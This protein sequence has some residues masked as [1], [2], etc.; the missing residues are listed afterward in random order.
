MTAHYSLRTLI[1][2]MH[3]MSDNISVFA[4]VRACACVCVR[5]RVRACAS[6]CMCV[7]V[8]AFACLCAYVCACVCMCV[9]EC[10]CVRTNNHTADMFWR[11][12]RRWQNGHTSNNTA[13]IF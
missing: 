10:L 3:V 2:I 4:C 1:K 7:S 12:L 9:S 11:V 6:A 13:Q 5:V 8:R